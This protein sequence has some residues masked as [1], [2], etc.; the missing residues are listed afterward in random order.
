MMKPQKF[1]LS[2]SMVIASSSACLALAMSVA[3]ASTAETVTKA[4]AVSHP[5]DYFAADGRVVTPDQYPTAETERQMLRA[6]YAAGINRFLHRRRLTPTDQQTVVRMNRDTYYSIALVDVSEGATVTL[7]EIPVGKYM[8]VQ[9]LPRDHRTQPM[10][11]GPGSYELATHTGKHLLLI[12]R[13]DATFSE[14]E[15]AMYQDMMG[16]TAKSATRLAVAPIEPNSFKQVEAQL[17]AQLP[18]LLKRDGIYALRGMFTSPTDTSRGL[19]DHQK[20]LVGAAGGWGGAQWDDNIYETSGNYPTGRCYAATFEDPKNHAFW[21]IAVYN[22]SGFM[23]NDVANVS[24]D[25]ATRNADGTYTV[26]F[27]CGDDAS[28][29]LPIENESGVFNLS[30]R[31][32]Q[33]SDR[34]KGDGYRVLPFLKAQ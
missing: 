28:N 1:R 15:A 29:N 20:Y 31:H 7:P 26:S 33:P 19:F 21:S 22:Q 24:S 16:I 11:Y 18:E 14:D 23:F 9:P 13:L 34:I 12:V 8:S 2:Q 4:G 30:V 25:T 10:S 6:Q 32:Y 17:K 3:T 5:K 27:G